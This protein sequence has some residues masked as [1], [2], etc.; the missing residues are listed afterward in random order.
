MVFFMTITRFICGIFLMK[1]PSLYVVFFLMK[2]PVCWHPG[3]VLTV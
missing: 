2:Y 3:V 1:L